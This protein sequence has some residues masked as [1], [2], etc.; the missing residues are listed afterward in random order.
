[1]NDKKLDIIIGLLAIIAGNTLASA[2]KDADDGLSANE[3]E[4]IAAAVEDCLDAAQE[5]ML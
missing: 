4:G 3:V 1:M 5:V 2:S